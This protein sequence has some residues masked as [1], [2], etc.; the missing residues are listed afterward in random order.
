MVSCENGI[1]KGNELSK[2]DLKYIRDLGL[3]NENE[4]IILFSSQ[5][6][7]RMSGNFLSENRLASY[8]VENRKE[9][10]QINSAKFIEIDTL[11]TTDLSEAL[12]YASYIKVI[13]K[14]SSEFKVYVD[15]KPEKI[16]EFFEKAISEWKKRK[17]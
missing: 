4:K 6:G 8:W 11:I 7:N 15:G 9:N 5:G 10:N 17:K 14:N 13:K 3:L 16:D 1:K 12:T 2:S